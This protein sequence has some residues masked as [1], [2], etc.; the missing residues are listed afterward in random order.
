MRLAKFLLTAV[1]AFLSVR[2]WAGP[3]SSVSQI[4]FPDETTTTYT[5]AAGI[6][7]R[8]EIVGTF[9]DAR[10][11]EHGFV[12]RKGEFT[13]LEVLG[14]HT[15]PLGIND[16]GDI[17]GFGVKNGDAI[18]GLLWNKGG[19]EPTQ[20]GADGKNI[21][22]FHGIN[23]RGQVVG[24]SRL[25]VHELAEAFLWNDGIFTSLDIP[26]VL[27][28]GRGRESMG[29]NDRGQVVGTCQ[30]QTPPGTHGFLIERGVA[31]LIDI[32]VPG[33]TATYA[34]GINNSGQIVGS[35]FDANGEH[36]YLR[37][38]NGTFTLIQAP[39]VSGIEPVRLNDRGDIVGMF[40]A[41]GK[42]HG[43]L[44][45]QPSSLIGLNRD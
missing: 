17:V 6:N 26:G 22:Y 30:N 41:G 35:Y 25:N 1:L 45:S 33:V 16:R 18:Q 3:A 11:F 4:D 9:R 44:F 10:P 21:T 15:I 12:F 31:T 42:F 36:G 14:L 27:V 38:A 24:H 20:I 34:S 39:N 5:D 8:G 43:F 2:T 28:V 7:N 13:A 40:S 23:N 32:P 29:I 19:G 37:N